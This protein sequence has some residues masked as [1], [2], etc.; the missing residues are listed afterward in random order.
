MLHEC[1]EFIIDKPIPN[2]FEHSVTR[3]AQEAKSKQL[4]PMLRSRQFYNVPVSLQRHPAVAAL[5]DSCS[6]LLQVLGYKECWRIACAVLLKCQT[7]L[8]YSRSSSFI[9][10]FSLSLPAPGTSRFLPWFL[11]MCNTVDRLADE[12]LS[13]SKNVFA[14]VEE[15]FL[16]TYVW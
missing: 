9:T 4:Y 6:A 11:C 12:D 14:N 10:S 15:M 5:A 3:I 13:R 16:I 7:F 1:C 8:L 2:V